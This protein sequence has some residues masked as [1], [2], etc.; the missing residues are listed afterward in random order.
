MAVGGVCSQH[1]LMDNRVL[2]N[3]LHTTAV[4]SQEGP[5]VW[6]CVDTTPSQC[7]RF[8]WPSLRS[9]GTSCHTC[10]PPGLL[11]PLLDDRAP[12]FLSVLSLDGL[13]QN[14]TPSFL[15]MWMNFSRWSVLSPCPNCPL[16]MRQQRSCWLCF[17]RRAL[18][19]P[20]VFVFL[21]LKLNFQEFPFCSANIN[22]YSFW[23]S[24]TPHFI[25]SGNS[26][27]I[28]SMDGFGWF[29]WCFVVI[30]FCVYGRLCSPP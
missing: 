2:Q 12:T 10:A 27:P 19:Q 24:L 20:T 17:A 3:Q 30:W 29:F 11:R 26:T 28:S 22:F 25:R 7:W 9:E 1:S 18:P 8:S 16:A 13:F 5:G 14:I 4:L 21:L 6:C 23:T 15:P